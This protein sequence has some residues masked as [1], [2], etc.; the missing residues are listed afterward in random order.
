MWAAMRCPACQAD[1][2]QGQFCLACGA[3]S[4]GV[5]QAAIAVLALTTFAITGSSSASDEGRFPSGTVLAE[6]YRVLDFLGRGGMGEVYRAFDLKLDQIVALKFLPAATADNARLLERFRGEVRLVGQVSHRNVC[7]VH[8]IGDADG[9]ALDPRGRLIDFRGVP[10]HGARAICPPALAG[11]LGGRL[12]DQLVCG[13]LLVGF[14]LGTG[15]AVLYHTWLAFSRGASMSRSANLTLAP[16]GG[17]W[18]RSA[19]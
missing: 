13:D 9:A 16:A 3:Q 18:T 17:F 6:R 1:V 12:R 4:A 5:A 10:L 2:P 8:D 19:S 14:A 15:L 7:R 11:K